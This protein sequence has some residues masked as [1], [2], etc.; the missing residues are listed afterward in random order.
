M[1]RTKIFENIEKDKSIDNTLLPC[2]FLTNMLR[3]LAAA[4]DNRI[5][6]TYKGKRIRFIEANKGKSKGFFTFWALFKSLGFK[7][8]NDHFYTKAMDT[9]EINR[10][11]VGKAIDLGICSKI[12]AKKVLNNRITVL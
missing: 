6:A 11:I 10:Y 8:D 2:D 9:N 3:Y 7:N 1:N 4:Q 12:R 5:C